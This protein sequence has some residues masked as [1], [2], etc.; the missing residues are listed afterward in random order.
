MVNNFYRK[1]FPIDSL[2][3]NP[4]NDE[5]ADS[6]DYHYTVHA[7]KDQMAKIAKRH[8]SN[9]ISYSVSLNTPPSWSEGY[10]LNYTDLV[11]N[12]KFY[13]KNLN[14][15]NSYT[16]FQRFQVPKKGMKIELS[17]SNLAWYGRVIRAYE[18]HDLV[19]KQDGT[20]MIDGKKATSYT[21]EMNYYWMMGDNRYNSVD[22]RVWGFVPED[23]IVGKAS[24]VWF[25]KD[26]AGGI[27]WDRLFT[28]IE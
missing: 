20:V 26:P 18:N 22:S 7:T 21:F 23:H 15:A 12:T 10:K 11:N 6:M 19:V 28:G 9:K 13:P 2:Y 8:K 14:I 24:M 16:D 27:R 1:D 25:S 5:S 3:M 4:N 17:E